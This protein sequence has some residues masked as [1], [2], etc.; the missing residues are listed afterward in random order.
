MYHRGFEIQV[1]KWPTNPAKIIAKYISKLPDNLSIGDFG[2]GNAYIA[3]TV[4]Q[5]VHSF[6]LCK[7]NEY[8]T[9]ANSAAVPLDS[10]KL[11]IAVFCLS[12]MGTDFE[13]FLVE[14]R[15]TL[16]VKGLLIVAEVK[17]RFS[18]PK[19]SVEKSDRNKVE[20][21]DT[22][23][24][25]SLKEHDMFE[26]ISAFKTVL[27]DMG[28]DLQYENLNNKMFVLFHFLKRELPL[29]HEKRLLMKVCD[30]P[31]KEAILKSCKYKKR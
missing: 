24:R 27:K 9:V 18:V 29:K 2:C 7:T 12:L 28:F 5:T 13:R 6:D 10:G 11:D 26:G 14:A 30:I 17:S 21:K 15:R 8:V 25:I 1:A 16:K 19:N 22:S 4:P 31:H 3:R 20:S 23:D